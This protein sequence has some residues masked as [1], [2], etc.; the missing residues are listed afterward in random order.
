MPVDPF[1]SLTSNRNWPKSSLREKVDRLRKL[2]G[3]DIEESID[4]SQEELQTDRS[5]E[6][7]LEFTTQNQTLSVIPQVTHM[8][9]KPKPPGPE[10]QELKVG[11]S[12]ARI[13]ELMC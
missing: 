6:K 1:R 5:S 7:S 2:R 8:R 4:Q 13:S 10:K 3:R 12:V 11:Q 9:P